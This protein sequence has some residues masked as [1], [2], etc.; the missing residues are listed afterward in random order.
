MA[1]ESVASDA[2]VDDEDHEEIFDEDEEL[3][4]EDLKKKRAEDWGKQFDVWLIRAA[5]K[6][7][8]VCIV[9][10]KDSGNLKKGEEVQCLPLR[11][12]RDFV[13]FGVGE[14]KIWINKS[15]L[16]SCK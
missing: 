8:P 11:I 3:S 12:D 15:Y 4:P 9:L 13:Q 14:E 5:R 1:E 6:T 16:V 2:S 10:A 7:R